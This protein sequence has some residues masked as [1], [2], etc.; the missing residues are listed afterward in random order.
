MPRDCTALPIW[1]RG[2]AQSRPLV[3]GIQYNTILTMVTKVRTGRKVV[4]PARRPKVKALAKAIEKISIAPQVKKKKPFRKFGGAAGSAIG[5]MFGSASI[6]KGV[7]KWLGSGIGSIFGS[8]AYETMGSVPKYNILANSSQPPQFS[9]LRQTNVVCHR[10]YLGDIQGT[11]AFNNLTY[12][13]NPGLSAT[14]PWLATVAANYQ[15][16]RFH[17]LMFEFR[18]LITDFIPNGAP[19]VVIMSTN[20][21]ASVVPYATKQQMENAEYAVSVKPTV[22]MVHGVECAVDQTILPERFIRNG[23]VPIGQDLRLYDLGL[24]QFATQAN[25]IQDLGELWV[26]YCVEFF[27]PILPV[28][29]PDAGPAFHAIRQNATA[30]TPLGGVAI[31]QSGSLNVALTTSSLTIINASPA[32]DYLVEIIWNPGTSNVI[33][34]PGI[35]FNNSTNQLFYNNGVNGQVSTPPNGVLSA[36]QTFSTTIVSTLSLNGNI[37]FTIPATGLY[38]AGGFIDIF[39][40]TLD[41]TVQG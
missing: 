10:E 8:G 9:T 26:S 15:E 25:P 13:L 31:R 41:P 1:L 12:A 21:N 34:M 18:S 20:Y 28:L 39:V 24:F 38:P 6:G 30:L 3:C 23:N 35:S 14:F 32:V 40:V 36:S 2:D 16:Y 17:G 22:D 27:K 29:G 19:G 11:T 5:G 4:M 37:G 7:G 33:N